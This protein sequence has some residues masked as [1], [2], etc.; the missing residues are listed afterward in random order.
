MLKEKPAETYRENQAQVPYANT[1]VGTIEQKEGFCRVLI[2]KTQPVKPTQ[3]Q[4][5]AYQQ[6]FDY[7][8]RTLFDNSLADCMLSFSRRRSSSHT[9]FTAE[10]WREKAGPAT[11]EISLNLKQLS[12]DKP[13]EV[14]ALLV[15]QMVHLWQQ[16]Y[17]SPSRNGYFNRKWAEKMELI[18]LMPSDTGLPGGRRTGQGIQHY[19][20]VEGRFAKAFREMPPAYLWPFLPT[21]FTKNAKSKYSQKM[22][23]QC[24]GCGTKVWGKGGIG[25]VCECGQ[26]FV[27]ETGETKA[28]LGEQVYCLLAKQYSNKE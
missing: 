23:Y 27:D 26:V 8:N 7:F 17:G 5:S 28:G 9:L 20:K 21:A 19:I 22:M 10:Q 14:M 18:G 2:Q 15:R 4:F 24:I 25:L 3:T 6:L 16:R 11:P 12:A 1:G 13:I